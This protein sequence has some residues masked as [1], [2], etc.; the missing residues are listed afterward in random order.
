MKDDWF[1]FFAGIT[2]MLFGIW[3]I[4][5]G[6]V[7]LPLLIKVAEETTIARFFYSLGTA[8]CAIYF[9]SSGVAKIFGKN[10]DKTKTKK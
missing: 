10:N 5:T 9:T 3:I 7:V 6:S 8:V 1:K 4:F 2:E